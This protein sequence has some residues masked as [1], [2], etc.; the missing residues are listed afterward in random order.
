LGSV[1]VFFK[2]PELFILATLFFGMSMGL[3]FYLRFAA[4]EVVPPHWGARAVTIV[5][6][7]GCIAAFLG[8]EST[9]AT[10]YMI[11]DHEYLGVMIMTG[12]YNI[13][14]LVF[15]ILVQFPPVKQQ[16]KTTRRE[17]VAIMQ[18]RAFLTPVA[19]SA[20]SW[21]IMTMPMAVLRVAMQQV[22]FTSRQSLLAIELHFLGMYAPGFITGILI[23]RW[24]PRTVISSSI[25]LFVTSMILLQNVTSQSSFS[26]AESIWI[27]GMILIG[28]V[29]FPT[30]RLYSYYI[31][32]LSLINSPCSLL[33]GFRAGILV[34]M[35]QLFW[36]QDLMPRTLTAS[37]R[38]RLVTI[39]SC[40]SGRVAGLSVPAL[41]LRRVVVDWGDGAS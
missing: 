9:R 29:S 3:A 8:P 26:G 32:V 23:Q 31:P 18:T 10:Q 25:V 5:V 22:G 7:G 1:S 28:V 40:F 2:L 33:L 24:G 21:A 6:S 38:F 27:L 13:A 37:L 16:E 15:T 34:S 14:G 19:A 4:V 12:I 36:P 30:N 11:E 35:R 20:F 41:S 17:I 39:S